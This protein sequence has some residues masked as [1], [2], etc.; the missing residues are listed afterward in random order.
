ME[1]G[2]ETSDG[3]KAWFECCPLGKDVWTREGESQLA[4]LSLGDLLRYLGWCCSADKELREWLLEELNEPFAGLEVWDFECSEPP[5]CLLDFFSRTSPLW[6][7]LLPPLLLPLFLW[8]PCPPESPER[9]CDWEEDPPGGA[10]TGVHLL[11]WLPPPLPTP[12]WSPPNKGGPDFS[13]EEDEL[14][15]G[16]PGSFGRVSPIGSFISS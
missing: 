9:F 5:L 7:L 6:L 14:F 16:L 12:R 15:E 13:S 2:L 10:P 11:L 8:L 4:S 1:L 3:G